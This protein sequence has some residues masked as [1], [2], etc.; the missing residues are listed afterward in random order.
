VKSE[1][2][3][4]TSLFLS[5][6]SLLL[7]TFYFLLSPISLLPFLSL[8][9]LRGFTFS[10]FLAQSRKVAIRKIYFLP[11]RLLFLRVFACNNSDKSQRCDFKSIFKEQSWPC[12][13]GSLPPGT[14][15]P[16]IGGINTKAMVSA[17]IGCCR[18]YGVLRKSIWVSAGG[19]LKEKTV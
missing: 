13:T 16:M 10:F 9:V 3:I 11:S 17:Y 18:Y 15:V 4:W 7:P 12:R 5:P 14:L 8:C 2:L 19:I 6:F 1:N